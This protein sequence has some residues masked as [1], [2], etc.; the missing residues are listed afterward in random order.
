MM[1][2]ISNRLRQLD[3]QKL[4]QP[5]TQNIDTDEKNYASWRE[6]AFGSLYSKRS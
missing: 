3:T 6:G 4:E 5:K 1:S 2:S